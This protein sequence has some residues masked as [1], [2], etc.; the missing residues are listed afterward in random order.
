VTAV[1]L[2]SRND[3]SLFDKGFWK[4][5]NRNET[6]IMLK[7]VTFSKKLDSFFGSP[8]IFFLSN[9]AEYFKTLVLLIVFAWGRRNIASLRG[10]SVGVSPVRTVGFRHRPRTSLIIVTYL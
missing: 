4:E 1:Y 10:K 3:G 2:I 7:I 8:N 9:H 5:Q 6:A